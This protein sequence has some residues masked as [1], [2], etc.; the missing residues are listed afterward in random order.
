M[1]IDVDT[2]LLFTPF[3]IFLCIMNHFHICKLNLTSAMPLQ[4]LSC[5]MSYNK[6][7]CQLL[8]YWLMSLNLSYLVHK[9]FSCFWLIL[10]LLIPYCVCFCNK[11]FCACK[12]C[13]DSFWNWSQLYYKI[14][15]D[16]IR[17]LDKNCTGH[18]NIS[19]IKL[20]IWTVKLVTRI[21]YTLL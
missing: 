6:Y 3:V 19:Y 10:L 2:L 12:I 11:Y 15:L 14:K 1:S 4:D 18:V 21:F 7:V 8:K 16:F 9:Y 20:F 13:G 17:P 5:T